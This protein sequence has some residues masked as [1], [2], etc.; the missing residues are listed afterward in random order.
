MPRLRTIREVG[1]TAH[2]CF[3]EGYKSPIPLQGLFLY[4][5]SHLNINIHFIPN[6]TNL[7]ALNWPRQAK[8]IAIQFDQYTGIYLY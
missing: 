1:V 7:D 6:R 8:K 2:E 5:D 4:L 3:S